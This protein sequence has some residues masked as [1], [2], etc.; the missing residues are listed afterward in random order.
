MDCVL[1]CPKRGALTARV[2]GR[3]QMPWWAWPTL[4][5]ALWLA[6]YGIAVLTGH[7]HSAMP[8]AYF[9]AA[10]RTLGL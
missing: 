8:E 4:V 5:V 7:W 3:F 6:V 2:L 1:A 9:A 10:V